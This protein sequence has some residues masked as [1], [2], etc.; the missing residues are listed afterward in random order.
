MMSVKLRSIVILA[1]CLLS[2]RV[3]GAWL[4]DGWQYRMP[5]TLQASQVEG[6]HSGFPVLIDTSNEDAFVRSN[7]AANVAQ[8]GGEDIV[9]TAADGTSLLEHEI[10]FFDA[11]DGRLVAWVRVPA[12]QDTADTQLFVYYGNPGAA[13]QQNVT[14]VWDSGYRLVQHLNEPGVEDTVLN[15]STGNGNNGTVIGTGANFPTFITPSLM[16]GG[17]NLPGNQQGDGGPPQPH[18]EFPHSAS[19]APTSTLTA[20]VWA[21]AD[22]NLGDGLNHH[23]IL[24]KGRKVGWGAEYLF[25]IVVRDGSVMTWGV[26]C[27]N[28]EGWFQS[29][30]P[31]FG[32]WAHY[33][34]T[35]DGTT[36]RAYING[37]QVGSSTACSG[38]TLNAFSSEPLRSGWTPARQNLN[39]DQ[40]FYRGDADEIRISATARSQQWLRTQYNTQSAPQAYH[41]FGEQQ[42]Q[43]SPAAL[44]RMEQGDWTGATGEVLDSS[45]NG[46]H[47]TAFGGADTELAEPAIAGDPGTCAYGVFDG[48]TGYVEIPH[49]DALNGTDALTYA[50][51]INPRSHFDDG[52]PRQVMAKSVHGGGAGRAQMGLFTENSAFTARVETSSGRINVTAA[53]P[54]LDTWTHVA[55]V[56]NGQS[57]VLYYNGG[58]VARADFASTLLLEN[59]DPLMI[60]KR[61]GSDQYF[62]DGYIDEARVYTSA[63]TESEIIAIRDDVQPCAAQ[64]AGL[65][66]AYWF[67]DDWADVN[68]A[69][70]DISGNGHTGDADG[71]LFSPAGPTG[72][73]PG[74]PG[75][76]GYAEVALADQMTSP[77][78]DGIND[79]YSF[80]LT[81]WL[82]MD[83]ND[84]N[85]NTPSI[86]AGGNLSTF[87]AERFEVLAN[88]G[89]GANDLIFMVRQGANDNPRERVVVWNAPAGNDPFDGQWVHIVA[90]HD[91]DARR[92]SIHAN[93]S[94]VASTTY[95]NQGPDRLLNAN[96]PIQIGGFSSGVA[97]SRL[98]FD[99]F[100]LVGRALA[101]NDIQQLYQEA[102]PC[103]G[104]G[105]DRFL[106]E[107]PASASVCVPADIKL[108]ALDADGNV[109]TDYDG[110]VA[111]STSS[112]RGNWGNNTGSGSL[113]PDPHTAN[114]GSAN[115]QFAAG[116]NGVVTL[117]LANPSADELTIT[118]TD[119]EGGQS[120]VSEPVAYLE[121][122]FVISIDDPLATDFIAERDHGLRLEA[123][124]RD[125]VSGECG[126]ITDYDGDVGLK[127]WLDRGS[128]DPGGQAPS[129]AAGS[130]GVALPDAEPG[131]NNL[132]AAFTQG[133]AAMTWTTFDVG[134]Y[135]LNLKDDSSGIVVDTNG[136]P[137]AVVGS[138][139]QWTVRP[140]HFAIDVTDNPEAADAD[141]PVFI[142]AGSPFEVTVTALGAA[143]N[144][145][146]SYGQEGDPQGVK[147]SHT[148]IAPAVASASAGNLSGTVDI[149]GEQFT[150]GEATVTDIAWDEVGIIRLQAA[151]DSYLGVSPKVEGELANVGRF[152][153][154]HFEVTADPGQIAA[155]CDSSGAFAYS[156]QALDWELKPQLT[157]TA[158]AATGGVTGNYTLGG[159]MKLAAG[160]IAR[161]PPAADSTAL[162]DA[163]NPYPVTSVL[164]QGILTEAAPGQMHYDFADA[165]SFTY[166]KILDSLVA[167]FTPDLLI[168]LDALADSDGVAAQDLPM[169]I[170]PDTGFKLRYGR[171]TMDNV[172][173][174]ENIAELSMPFRMEYWNGTR[175]VLNTADDCTAWT[176]GDI[177]NPEIHHLMVDDSGNFTGG[178]GGPLSLQPK[179][180]SGDDVLTWLVPEDW[181]KDD[182]NEDG[183]LDYPSALATFGVYRGHDRVIYWREQ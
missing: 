139:A 165:D 57:L 147:L 164:D 69:V 5:I 150:D 66:T 156:G 50:A 151:N 171:L 183:T 82:R 137:I 118:V 43:T 158:R 73:R 143:G 31:R 90:R 78:D 155:Y 148:L 154:G 67:D 25:R 88:F 102:R 145:L 76:C 18:L 1:I 59:S 85:N 32:E 42:L 87:F 140:D 52:A 41:L 71:A 178:E 60:G 21:R 162:N 159:F 182:V 24:F 107:A 153:P 103:A 119:T 149:P 180:T 14:A 138:S 129:L 132:T 169:P 64:L 36:T 172:Y 26:T 176:T 70:E 94:E 16:D 179:N 75:T 111:L 27:G 54:P 20:E 8:A 39:N 58:E 110:Q 74:S 146:V 84:Q 167:P 9:F 53:L 105:L 131:S 3:S 115:Y 124:S 33:A 45:G 160:D 122:A 93:G 130:A 109:L 46:L 123:V 13:D 135:G 29:G 81:F 56:F 23:P 80:S 97:P 108:S 161:T 30:S 120:G 92:L 133:V 141:G 68:D 104:V 11:S 55:A 61:V 100:R 174:P 112:G 173:G 2:M 72:A 113:F 116:D 95:D 35:F 86:V 152:I 134:Q 79:A 19:L 163:G 83:R 37:E 28:L 34:L 7:L 98:D 40:S 136:D 96:N 12:I 65:Q 4:D 62:W 15:D 22:S 114:D 175:F 106:V 99:E 181:Q 166:V 49:N 128:N 177:T 51:W 38:Q 17:R 121:N 142:A 127:A 47:G 89:S 101:D 126:L 157:I 91:M 44:Y 144:P 170:E 10:E 63:L 48:S 77:V 117:Q 6:A 125:P 168:T